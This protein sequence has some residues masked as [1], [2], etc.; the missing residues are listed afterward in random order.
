VWGRASVLRLLTPLSTAAGADR[1]R[2]W[3]LSPASPGAAS[4]RHDA[5]RQLADDPDL[6]QEWTAAARRAGLSRSDRVEPFLTWAEEEAWSK[7]HRGLLWTARALPAANVAL[8][9]AHAT[10]LTAYPWWAVGLAVALAVSGVASTRIHPVFDRVT[11]GETNVARHRVLLERVADLPGGSDQL[12]EARDAVVGPPDAR[13]ALLWLERLISASDVRR[14][15]LA[16][17]PLQLL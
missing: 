8:M 17:L 13:S 10:G 3:L 2:R 16:H 7:D 4:A 1:A 6:R 5:A 12:E 15:A 14:N 9:V 11:R